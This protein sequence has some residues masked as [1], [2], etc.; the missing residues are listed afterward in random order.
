V[1]QADAMGM[2]RFLLKADPIRCLT[3]MVLQQESD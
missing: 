1:D 3:A 2:A